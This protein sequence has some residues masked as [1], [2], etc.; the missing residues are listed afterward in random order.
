MVS[1]LKY[2]VEE[3]G[4]HIKASKKRHLWILEI[5]GR[6]YNLVIEE[7]VVSNK[8]KLYINGKMF[9]QVEPHSLNKCLYL[10]E[11]VL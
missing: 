9:H 6:A 8:T 7:S 4:R 3:V 2:E 1:A 11:F 10:H 5:S